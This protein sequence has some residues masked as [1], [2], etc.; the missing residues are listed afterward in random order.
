[1]ALRQ[2]G[3]PPLPLEVELAHHGAVVLGAEPEAGAGQDLG[4]PRRRA[5]PAGQQR[6]L[7]L[8]AVERGVQGGQVADLQGDDDEA[9]G[10][11]DVVDRGER[12]IVRARVTEGQQ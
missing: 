11:S 3:G 5:G 10:R 9:G 8:A 4:A 2:V 12:R 1:M 7:G 6:H